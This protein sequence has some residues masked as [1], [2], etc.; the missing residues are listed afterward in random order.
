MVKVIEVT[1]S[2]Q[3]PAVSI[4][5]GDIN[6]PLASIPPLVVCAIILPTLLTWLDAPRSRYAWEFTSWRMTPA[7]A[8]ETLKNNTTAAE[9]IRLLIVSSLGN[10][11]VLQPYR[12]KRRRP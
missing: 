11:Q 5:V 1:S 10:R 12:P 2:T 9:V 4:H 7:N 6:T 8:P 3:C